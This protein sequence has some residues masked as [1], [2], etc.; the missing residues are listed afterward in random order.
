MGT[1]YFL[2]TINILCKQLRRIYPE[3]LQKYNCD[4]KI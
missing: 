3:V 1:S 2:A 4:D